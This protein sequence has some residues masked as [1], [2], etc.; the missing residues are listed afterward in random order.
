M[1]LSLVDGVV[2]SEAVPPWANTAMDGYAVRAPDTAGAPVTLRVTGTLLAGDAPDA[3]AVGAGE[4]VRIMTGAPIPAGA[5]AVVMVERTR[6]APEP[7]AVVVEEQARPG[8]HIR[9]AGSDVRAGDT[10]LEAGTELGPVHLGLL[11][12]I[13]VAEVGVRRRPRVGVMSTGDEL[14]GGA[15]PLR[16]GQI[17]DANR[18][19]LLALVAQADCRPVDLGIV[20]DDE[21]ALTRALQGALGRCDA[22]I[23]SGGVS[24]GDVDLVKVV[25]DRLGDMSWMQI[26]IKPAKPLAFGVIGEVP[27]FGLPGN[28]VSSLVSFELFA[29]PGLRQMMGHDPATDRRWATATL[30]EPLRRRSDGKLHLLRVAL[31]RSGG[32]L[33]ARSAGGQGSHQLAA[34]ARAEGL[35]AVPDGEGL[36]RGE[37]VEVLLLTGGRGIPV[38][39][40][41]AGDRASAAGRPGP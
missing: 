41:V 16:P 27:V 25:L 33:W 29:R 37:E 17:R 28:P 26:A 14:V 30:D 36:D 12:G 22:V 24:V 35:A 19:M 34:A 13:G 2:A 15:A 39:P 11:A 1:G 23:S 21:A 8:D 32:R 3:V 9:P 40:P 7:G 5:D 38:A 10:V 4:A 18:P 20:G 31:R 6:P